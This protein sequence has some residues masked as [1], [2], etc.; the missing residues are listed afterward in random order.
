MPN[1]N[2]N[3]TLTTNSEIDHN[4]QP[5]SNLN[6]NMAQVYSAKVKLPPFW[7]EN[8][9]LWFYQTEA[10]FSVAKIRSDRNKYDHV[11]AALPLEVISNIFDIIQNPPLDNLYNQLK[12]KLIKRFTASEEQ[13]LDKLLSVSEIGNRKPSEFF[14]ALSVIAGGSTL[15]NRELLLKIWKRRLPKNI[16]IAIT[17]S[18]KSQCDDILDLADQVWETY[19]DINIS[20]LGSSNECSFNHQAQ[21]LHAFTDFSSKCTKTFDAI[22]NNNLELEKKVNSLQLQIDG[23]QRDDFKQSRYRRDNSKPTYAGKTFKRGNSQQPKFCFYHENYKHKALKCEGPW[24]QF[25]A[26]NQSN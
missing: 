7:T 22:S 11:I 10:Q 19:N 24:C 20:A 8:P 12:Q 9:E 4:V 25:L 1:L 16:L 5:N 23:I 21:M 26:I 6:D 17:A 2:E 15:V 14:R 3:V 18:G 13:R